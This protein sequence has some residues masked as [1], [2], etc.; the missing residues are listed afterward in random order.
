MILLI[1]FNL[2][3]ENYIFR[4]HYLKFSD[5]IFAL[6][7]ILRLKVFKTKYKKY[8]SYDLS[9]LIIS[10]ISNL[11]NF[12]TSIIGI[13][14]YLFVKRLKEANLKIK[15]VYCWF[16]NHELKGWNYG[17]EDIFPILTLSAIR[18]LPLSPLMNTIPTRGEAKAKSYLNVV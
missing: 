13:L 4:E 1:I 12:D 3:N 7:L 17:L 14:N 11:E 6:N 10:E 18:D 9:N 15:K 16:E 5:L 8:K 2:R